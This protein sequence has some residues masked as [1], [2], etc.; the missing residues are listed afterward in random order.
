MIGRVWCCITSYVGSVSGRVIH[1]SLM[2]TDGLISRRFIGNIV[3]C[4]GIGR[5]T[6]VSRSLITII[7]YL[8]NIN[9]FIFSIRYG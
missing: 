6:V 2:V 5:C 8:I 1:D 9:C 4:C 7:R 3:L